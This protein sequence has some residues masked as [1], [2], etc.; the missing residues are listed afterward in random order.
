MYAI[1]SYYECYS[2]QLQ[3]FAGNC[4]CDTSGSR[5]QL[6]PADAAHC[7]QP[8][9]GRSSVITSY[10]IHY[11]KL[12]DIIRGTTAKTRV[13]ALKELG[14]GKIHMRVSCPPHKFPCYY[15]IDFSSKGELIAAR[16]PIDELTEYL[17]LDSLHYLSIE[18]MLEA[19][20]VDEPEAN[21]CKACFDG[22]FV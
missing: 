18:G 12:Y 11:T 4:R 7:R 20:G 8:A 22:T 3:T 16:M 9:H 6:L 2:D 5:H 21:F 17:G 15:G 10:S 19:S 14:A 13:K 1:R